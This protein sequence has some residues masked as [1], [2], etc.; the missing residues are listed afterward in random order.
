MTP[1]RKPLRSLLAVALACAAVPALAQQAPFS[2]TVFFGDS[3]TDSGHFRPALVGLLGPNGALIGKFTT[4]PGLVWSEQLAAYYGT[5]ATSDNQGGTNY[6]VGGA[7]T[8][9]DTVGGLGAIPSL[10]SQAAAYLSA[11][12]GEADPDALYSV[13]GGANDMFTIADPATAPAIIGGAV[14]A[15]AGVVGAL[16]AAGAQYVLVAN[17]PDLGLTPASR[18]GGAAG[19][20][21]G[22]A[23]ATAYNDALFGALAGANL[24]VIPV[25]AFHFLQ[26]VVA[27]PAGYGLSNVTTPGCL[28]QPAPAGSSSL[29]CNPASYADPSV[30]GSYLFADAIHPSTAAH[31]MVAQLA[32][33]MIEGPRQIAVLP[34]V[35]STVGR[36]RAGRVDARLAAPVG[37]GSGMRWWFDV[38]GDSQRYGKGDVYDGIGPAL[39]VGVDWR[40]G[41]FTYGAFGGY[42]RQGMD[43]GLGRGS[44]DQ[45]DATIGGYV[46]WRSGALWVDGQA[47]YT[48]VSYDIDR[49]VRIGPMTRVHSGSPD[50]SNLS[51]GASAGW[52][53][54]DGAFRHG[55]VVS[56]LSQQIDVDGYA[57]SD[58]ELSSSLAY[59][60]QSFDSLIGSAGWQFSWSP[61]DRIHP[62]GRVTWDRE[63]EDAPEQA[64]ASAQSIPVSLQYAVP[65]VAFDD[66]YGTLMLGA[67]TTLMGLDANV[68][69]SLTFGQA[70]GNDATVFVSVG[71]RF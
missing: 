16:Q 15:E 48:Q 24:P 32:E 39:T 71:N 4:N 49:A 56:L 69:T 22:T 14:T 13:W 30:A 46:G 64:F 11:N 27:D 62:Y 65:G 35:E 23:I 45:D 19:M 51:V 41:G 29:F 34:H 60:D 66:S 50:G 55:P 12:G 54:G 9:T 33:S 5:D 44:F 42:G 59:P 26:E 52:D 67:R 68:G 43:W 8:G 3:L 1:S 37:E 6:A 47:S 53:F 28:T 17:L 7:L 70:G 25:D 36:A 20:A 63:F 57:E 18:A 21:Q 10:Q 40:S 58:P 2:Q 38:R 31:A 61:T